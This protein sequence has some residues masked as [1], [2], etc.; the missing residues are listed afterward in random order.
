MPTPTA[1]LHIRSVDA[2]HASDG[3]SPR[4]RIVIVGIGHGGMACADA[5]KREA[6][7]VLVVDRHNFHTFQPLLYQVATAGLDVDDVTQPAR[8]ILRRQPNADFRLATVVGADFDAQLL[9]TQAGAAI[10][11]DAL[12][13]AA[14]ATTATYGVA[15]VNEHAFPLKSA[16]DALA[17]RSHVLARFEAANANPNLVAEGALTVAIVGGGATGVETAGALHELFQRVLAKDFPG[18]DVGGARVVLVEGGGALMAAYDADLQAYTTRALEK[19]GVEVRLGPNATRVTPAGVELSDGTCIVAQTVV[20]AA[21]VT[22]VPLAAALGL[23]QT[24]GGRLAVDDTLRVPGRDRVFVIGD[25]AG[26]TDANGDLYPQVAQV[27]IQQGRHAAAEIRRARAGLAPRPFVY[28]DPGMMA[29]IGRNAAI[30]QLPSGF[31]LH[32][33]LAWVGWLLVHV[34][35]LVGFR[36][37]ASVLLSWLYNYATYD[38]GPRLILP[39]APETPGTAAAARA[40]AA[41][42]AAG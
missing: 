30:L 17:L 24:R 37:R 12:V 18:L 39:S 5:L 26:A 14:G 22:A 7:D 32:G 13:L 15:G 3:L 31:K 27:A 33:I 41:E 25:L 35:A 11:Y 19:R 8:H 6:A 1:A 9:H 40:P 42:T 20:W 21:G 34:V 23:E 2:V 4:P 28:R 36:N 38:R 10:P 16:Q 29:T